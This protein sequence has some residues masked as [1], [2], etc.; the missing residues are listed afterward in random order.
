LLSPGC[1]VA[2]AEPGVD[3]FVLSRIEIGDGALLLIGDSVTNS[4]VDSIPF[5]YFDSKTTLN[6]KLTIK[7]H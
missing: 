7:Y 6:S 5:P 2:Y 1:G 4:S 3:G